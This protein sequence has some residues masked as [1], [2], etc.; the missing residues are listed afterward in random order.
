MTAA[1]TRIEMITILVEVRTSSLEGQL[2][3][4]S[5]ALDSLRNAKIFFKP[6]SSHRVKNFRD[7]YTKLHIFSGQAGFEPATSG[8]GD[9]RS[10]S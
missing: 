7:F 6:Y 1:I 10:T 5:S 9:R 8:F 4:F 2:T 3:F